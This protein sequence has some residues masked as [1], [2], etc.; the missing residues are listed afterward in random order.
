[1]K[2]VIEEG[3]KMAKRGKRW[4]EGRA[5]VDC[6]KRYGVSEAVDLLLNTPATKFDESVDAAIR[7]GVDPRHA[8]QMVRGAV[9]LPHGTGKTVRVLVFAQ[10]EAAQA[11]TEAGADY[12]GSDDLVKKIQDG[13]LDFDKVVATRDMMGKV[14]RL[15][16]VLGPRGLMPTPKVGT[17]VAPD[18]V[19]STV[20]ALQG[21]RIDFRVEKA[22]VVHAILGRRSM[23]PEKIKEN[24]AAFASEL[25]RLK[26]ASAKGLYFRGASISS[27]MSVGVRVDTNDLARVAE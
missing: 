10:G 2:A 23:G 4:R 20:K 9:A 14:G 8:D 11:A 19:G 16:R 6:D 3:E 5:S 18:Q 25:Q 15:G 12:V 24:L 22:G 17:V 27:T 13:W 7:L 1:V 21:G 26:P